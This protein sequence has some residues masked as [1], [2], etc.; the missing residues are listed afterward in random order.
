MNFDRRDLNLLAVFH[1]VAE[2]RSVTLAAARL[3]LSQPAVSHALNRL[4]DLV[5]DPL[6]VRTRNGFATTPRAEAMISPVRA[7]LAASD[8]IFSSVQFDPATTTQTFRIGASDYAMVTIVP[9]LV[10]SLR[11]LAPSASL[12]IYPASGLLLDQL[13]NGMIDATFWG[14]APPPAL[15]RSQILFR[16]RFV[17]LLCSRHPLAVV[18]RKGKLSLDDYLA[19]PH[20]V[21]SFRDPRHSPIDARL[22]ELGRD[23]K[24]GLITPNFAA[25]IAAL[26]G[27]D[28][29]MSLPSRLAKQVDEQALVLFKLPI[30]VPDYS[31][32]L[33]WHGRAEAEPAQIWLRRLVMESAI[34]VR[35]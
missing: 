3:S 1:A 31:Y 18:A 21:V 34:E 13:E 9:G 5:Q 15:Y 24:K 26:P 33:V 23:R 20:V 19:Y 6:F 12:E 11:S 30:E 16:E 29:I 28:L 25:N 22:A 7:I 14:A 2:T 27:T 10:Q 35:S 8:L 4:R 32:S 17:G